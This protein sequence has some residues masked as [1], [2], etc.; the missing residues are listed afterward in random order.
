MED[1]L[2]KIKGIKESQQRLAREMQEFYLTLVKDHNQI[3]KELK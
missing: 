1:K 2:K 3:S